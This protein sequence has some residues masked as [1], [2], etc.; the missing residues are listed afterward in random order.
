VKDESG[1]T[2][3]FIYFEDEPGRR[4]DAGL[5]TRDEA[6]RMANGFARPHELLDAMRRKAAIADLSE[7]NRELLVAP[8]LLRLA[9]CGYKDRESGRQFLR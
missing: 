5:L 7:Q 3:A 9:H 2:L 6:R 4:T 8:L 1:Q